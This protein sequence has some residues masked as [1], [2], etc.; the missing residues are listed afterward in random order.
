MTRP[1]RL[2]FPEGVFHVFGRGNNKEPLFLEPDDYERFLARLRE[3]KKECPFCLLGYCLMPNHYHFAIQL[4]D[5]RLSIIMQRLLTGYARDFNDKYGRVGH[6]FQGR[7]G[8]RV[9]AQDDYLLRL[10]KYIHRNPVEAGLCGC[11]E[12]WSFSGHRA[13]LGKDDGLVDDALVL[14]LLHPTAAEARILYRRFV[15]EGGAALP[16][17]PA[18]GE[19]PILKVALGLDPDLSMLAAVVAQRSGVSVD[20]LRGPAQAR[21]ISLARRTFVGEAAARCASG[22]AIA[23]F[24]GRAPSS[25]S[26]MLGQSS[27]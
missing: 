1:L 15:D 16:D 23:R 8:S 17:L 4:L 6:V 25:V 5:A 24:L 14:G 7:Y 18:A 11:A 13:Y 3:I 10:V 19:E 21:S 20:A 12:D 27:N 26:R 9:C 2:Q 22:A